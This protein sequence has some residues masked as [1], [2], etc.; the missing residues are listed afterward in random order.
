MNTRY[1]QVGMN[2]HL[3]ILDLPDEILL[4]I[5]KNL[6]PIDGFYSLFQV[7]RRFH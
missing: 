5:L 6:N 7:N 1:H 4:M 3:N 2:N